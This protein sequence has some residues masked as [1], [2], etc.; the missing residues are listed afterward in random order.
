[1]DESVFAPG[2]KKWAT[3]FF[4]IWIGQAFSLVGSQVVQFAI[5]WWIT[6]ETGS[7]TMLATAALIG[8]LPQVIL[9]PFAGALVD[10]WNRR[11]VIIVADGISALALLS[12]PFDAC[13]DWPAL[14]FEHIHISG[15]QRGLDV[16]IGVKDL[17][18]LTKAR[19]VEAT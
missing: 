2:S 9:G 8:L 6:K 3:P 18:A 14:D 4:I 5:I 15:G 12:K 7:A 1:M 16:Q 17:I 13:L 11:I 19:T 10:R